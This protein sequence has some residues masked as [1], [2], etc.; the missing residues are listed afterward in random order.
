LRLLVVACFLGFPI[1][2][3]L[4]WVFDITSTGIKRTLGVA[5]PAEGGLGSGRALPRLA[6]LAVT[7][8]TMG[9]LGWWTIEDTL[10]SDA[11]AAPSGESGDLLAADSPSQ[12]PAVRSLAV[13]PLDDFS[14]ED[15][16]E[17]FTAGLHEEIVSRLSQMGPARVVS[18]TSVVQYDRSGKTMPAIA[19]DLGVDAVLE[20]SVF[21][22]GNRVRITVQLIH[23]PTDTHLWAE[24]Y[25]GTTDDAIAFQGEVA[26]AIAGGIQRKLSGDAPEPATPVTVARDV[27]IPE[28][29]RLGRRDEEEGTPEAL[30]SAIEHYRKVLEVD[31]SF[32]PAQTRLS[33]A[34]M[35]LD[36]RDPSG[37]PSGAE[38]RVAMA[39][40]L[41]AA[42][43][44]QEAEGILREVAREVEGSAEAWQAL[45]QIHA[46]RGDF[47]GVVEIRLERLSQ[48]LTGSG[49]STALVELQRLLSEQGEEGYWIWKAD[50][51]ENLSERGV[52]VSPVA[53]ARASVGIGDLQGALPHLEQAL[54]DGDRNLVTLWTD[55]AWDVLRSDPR[56]NQILIRIRR[57][58]PGGGHPYPDLPWPRP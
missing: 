9:G 1:V 24:S 6:L 2:L 50:E 28:E 38:H 41:A 44:Y 47:E 48:D 3:S 54:E 4:A 11:L 52:A 12:P 42:A 26:D 33:S 31:S 14:E 20:G 51:L 49:D 40:R 56:F 13:L 34:R 57:S 37:A 45:E 55:P 43:H 21:R 5:Y 39:R 35:Q 19:R 23:G 16:G 27:V 58:V 36:S 17:Y 8:S 22:A 7:L 30:A 53:L 15:G 29:Y 46:V 25:E 18:R 32:L 10:G